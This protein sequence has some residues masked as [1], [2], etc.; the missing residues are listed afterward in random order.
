MNPPYPHQRDAIKAATSFAVRHQLPPR[1]QEQMVSHLSL[2]FR[3]DSE[4]LQQQETLD[5]LPKAI[6]SGISHYLFFAL[7]QGVY[8]FQGVSNDLIFQLVLV[9]I[10]SS[11]IIH[12][13]LHPALNS[14]CL[15]SQCKVSEM[16]AEYFAPREDV[17]LQNE[18][19]SDFYILVTGSVV[20]TTTTTTTTKQTKSHAFFSA[21]LFFPSRSVRG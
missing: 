3:T 18:A 2:K 9:V 21:C 8:L 14:A 19:P 10:H 7:V 1:L 6:R 17:I 16:N 4:G 13:K 15:R 12:W 11:G 5:A 20:K